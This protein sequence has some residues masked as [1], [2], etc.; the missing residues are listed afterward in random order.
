MLL[1]HSGAWLNQLNS[2][3]KTYVY[4][5]GFTTTFLLPLVSFYLLK[6]MGWIS[7]FLMPDP[8]QRRVPL[9][10]VSFFAL[11][12]AFIL[13]KV[14]APVIF[15]LFL[16]G[17]SITLLICAIISANWKISIHLLGMGG[18]IGLILAISLKWML[19][20][21]MVLSFLIL[22]SAL[23]A[24]ARLRLNE[25][26]IYQVLAGLILGFTAIFLLIRFI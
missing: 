8:K 14:D 13:H 20:L 16:N 19:D 7:S 2:E 9:M 26:N 25:H 18:L 21:R 1:F 3:A 10:I 15:P 12:G 22:L 17:V 23:V 24:W 11:L 5:V 4:L 6:R